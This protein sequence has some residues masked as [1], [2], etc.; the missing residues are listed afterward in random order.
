M[1]STNKTNNYNLSQYIG[2]DKPTYLGDY[3]GDMLKIDTQMKN[4]A[5][6]A[7]EAITKA[8][9]ANAKAT[10]LE[11]EVNTVSRNV[12][13]LHNDVTT[14]K[15]NISQNTSDIGSLQKQVLVIEGK[16]TTIN[17]QISDIQNRL[18]TQWV[19]SDNIINTAIPSLSTA[20]SHFTVGYN[21]LTKELN[22]YFIIE[23]TTESTTPAGQVIATMPQEIINLLNLKSA[24]VI[25]N[26]CTVSHLNGGVYY[27]TGKNLRIDTNGQISIPAGTS[28]TAYI[29]G[30]LMLNTSAWS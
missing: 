26:G 19:N 14:I 4:N 5:S 9:E 18:N 10:S 1:S 15:N 7:T 21:K 24:R 11:E 17:A 2:T 8:G 16:T 13:T 27:D 28:T 12:A 29:Q 30:N 3:N 25:V 22:M 23:K 6:S 20:N